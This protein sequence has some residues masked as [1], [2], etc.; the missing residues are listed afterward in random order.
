MVD[1]KPSLDVIID[2]FL[3]SNDTEIAPWGGDIL[4]CMQPG[5]PALPQSGA[6]M[7]GMK[8]WASVFGA[9]SGLPVVEIP[10]HATAVRL[11]ASAQFER[12][13]EARSPRRYPIASATCGPRMS[14]L[15]ARSAMVR[16]TRRMRCIE[17]AESCSRSIALSSIAWSSGVVVGREPARRVRLRLVEVRIGAARASELRV[18][19]LHDTRTNDVAGFAGRCVGSQRRGRQ[20][21]DFQ[22]QVDAFEQRP[23]DAAAVTRDRVRMAAAAAGGIAGPAAGAR[24]HRGHELEARGEF[25]LPSGAGDGDDAG[26]QRFAQH[27]EG[28]AIPL[29]LVLSNIA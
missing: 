7:T 14:A 20:A 1:M 27:F 6:A 23:G 18:T 2:P 9:G 26:F 12:P 24:I 29:G 13:D 3:L 21:R 4:S 11:A 19:C 25:A 8:G 15:P 10:D 28:A 17:R 5:K 16:A 22:M